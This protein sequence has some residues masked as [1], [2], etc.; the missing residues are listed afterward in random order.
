M[1]NEDPSAR[2][3]ELGCPAPT[4]RLKTSL[5]VPMA[6]E[7]E[8]PIT[9]SSSTVAG[10]VEEIGRRG[11]MRLLQADGELIN[12]LDVR[13]NGTKIDLHPLRLATPLSAG[14]RLLI[15]L[16]PIGGG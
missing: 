3:P 12:F 9:A 14:D 7:G 10:M 13:L 4:I 11:G 1:P 6:D 8:I 5:L 16:V 15:Q 2:A